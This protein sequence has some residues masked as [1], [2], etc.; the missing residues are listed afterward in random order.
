MSNET[1]EHVADLIRCGIQEASRRRNKKPYELIADDIINND[2][3][4]KYVSL[5]LRCEQ[6]QAK[7]KDTKELHNDLKSFMEV[8]SGDLES[9]KRMGKKRPGEGN[10]KTH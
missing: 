5:A 6:N 3:I 9:D 2:A 8:V 4:Y 10:N 7:D 1:K